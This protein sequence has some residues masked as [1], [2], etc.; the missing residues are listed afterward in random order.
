MFIKDGERILF[1]TKT[2]IIDFDLASDVKW[3]VINNRDVIVPNP[4][5]KSK[6]LSASDND[7]LKIVKTIGSHKTIISADVVDDSFIAKD[8]LV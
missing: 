7:M 1:M 3:D 8:I 5:I 6:I 2:I 4:S